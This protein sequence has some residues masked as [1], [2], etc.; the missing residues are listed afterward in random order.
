MFPANQ[1][2]KENPSAVFNHDFFG[3]VES[4]GAI[5]GSSVYWTDAHFYT[6]NAA[7]QIENQCSVFQQH[8]LWSFLPPTSNHLSLNSWTAQTL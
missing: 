7:F 1:I 5:L 6:H 2:K 3:I 4:P 8:I